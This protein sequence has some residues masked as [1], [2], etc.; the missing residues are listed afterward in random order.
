MPLKS[1]RK[2]LWLGLV[3]LPWMGWGA[4]NEEIWVVWKGEGEAK[5]T[6]A[7]LGKW[8]KND[9]SSL[10][11]KTYREGSD[12]WTGVLL[13]ELIQ[14]GLS[15]LPAEKKATVDLVGLTS[16]G[17]QQVLIPRYV[18]VK[19]PVALVYQK[20]R[21]PIPESDGGPFQ[22]FIPSAAAKKITQEGLPVERFAL[23]QVHQIEPSNYQDR[24]GTFFLK[25]RTDPSAM[26]GEKLF[27]QSCLS[28]HFHGISYPA[29]PA[30]APQQA[31]ARNREVSS[32]RK[33][34][35]A[36]GVPNFSE[37]DWRA[38][39]SYFDAYQSENPQVSVAV[40][41]GSK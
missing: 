18:I 22:L 30:R 31:W 4:S 33:H 12:S 3:T 37:R 20:N 5:K 13:A 41:V 7:P 25:R 38:L 35:S 15:Q 34:P 11:V 28:C 32:Q 23:S 29:H 9:F 10:K 14:K 21:Q 1:L 2:Y 16:K 27:V 39:A 26:R 40:G 6:V 19:Y 36:S 17:G 8:S 24:F